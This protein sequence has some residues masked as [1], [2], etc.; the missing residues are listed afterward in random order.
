MRES[1]VARMPVWTLRH[2][3]LAGDVLLAA[4][5]VVGVH[6]SEPAGPPE[7][8]WWTTA[9]VLGTVLLRRRRPEAVLAVATVITAIGVAAR[10][11]APSGLFLLLSVLTYSAA[12]HSRH[13]RPWLHA[14]LAW[15]ATALAGFAAGPAQW[16]SPEQFSLFACVFGGAGIGD[17][18]R[19]R[20]AY[21]AEVTER[22]RQ[23]EETREQEARR[24][25]LDERLRIARELHDVVAHHIAV[26]SVHAGAAGHVLR[27][28]PDQVWPVLGHIRGAADAVLDEV[29]SVIGVLR[30][31]DEVPSTQ[32]TPG[33]DHL[34]ALLAGLEAAGFSVRREESGAPRRLPSVVDLAAYRIAQEALTNA[35]KHGDGSAELT[36]T[37]T[38]EGITVEVVNRIGPGRAGGPG[39]GFGLIGMGE[40]ASAAGGSLTSG[41]LPG[42][43]FR[44]RAELPAPESATSWDDSADQLPTPT[45]IPTGG[46]P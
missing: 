36:I 37:R 39:S 38:P 32:P 10:W 21:V 33:L 28:R 7:H 22:A 27:D 8:R 6:H 26:I 44:V 3:P 19:M 13:R 35:H 25:V 20:H 43:R 46:H 41:R 34:P 42:G 5:L 17:S 4:L 31:P 40:R 30:D 24:R 1:A 18:V 11:P 9:L 15:G 29:K 16:W 2:R 23:A 12:L 14:C 45:P